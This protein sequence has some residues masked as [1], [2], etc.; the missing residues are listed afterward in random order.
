MREET[1]EEVRATGPIDTVQKVLE[2]FNW[3]YTFDEQTGYLVAEAVKLRGV[4]SCDIS[5]AHDTSKNM[6]VIC[7]V[8][9]FSKSRKKHIAKQVRTF[10]LHLVAT[11]NEMILFGTL[12][13]SLEERHLSFRHSLCVEDVT[14]GALAKHIKSTLLGGID[15]CVAASPLFVHILKTSK[16]PPQEVIAFFAQPVEGEA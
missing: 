5:V 14:E 7:C 15:Y 3:S 12:S 11:I 9:V 16:W 6:L 4:A 2:E 10:V 13:C 8:C 1:R